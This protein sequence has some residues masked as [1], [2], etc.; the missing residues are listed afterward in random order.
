MAPRPRP[1]SHASC[2][3]SHV[4]RPTSHAP[5]PAP[6]D[7]AASTLYIRP[8]GG[9]T[10]Q[11]QVVWHGMEWHLQA[12]QWE[13]GHGGMGAWSVVLA[14]VPSC[15]LCAC[16]V[17]SWAPTLNWANGCTFCA[18]EWSPYLTPYTPPPW[19]DTREHLLALET[20]R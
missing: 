1:H 6:E 20:R 8:L 15:R 4:P 2:P 7:F 19:R 5:G 10:H 11:A 18:L 16:F 17:C 13:H 9:F 14:L 3:M 12:W